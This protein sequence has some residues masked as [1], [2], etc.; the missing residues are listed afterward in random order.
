ME[1]TAAVK[2]L[3]TLFDDA[4][5]ST[6]MGVTSARVLDVP[7]RAKVRDPKDHPHAKFLRITTMQR[8]VEAFYARQP[9]SRDLSAS[10]NQSIDP[11]QHL[12]GDRD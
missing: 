8:I 6:L 9:L 5:C 7:S 10:V 2:T 3:R 1:G 4:N 11:C 12:G